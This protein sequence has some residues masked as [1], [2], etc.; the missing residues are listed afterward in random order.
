MAAS[1]S[2]IP[3]FPRSHYRI[4]LPWDQ[5]ERQLS[6]YTE[7]YALDLNPEFQRAHVWNDAQRTAYMEFKLMGGP[8]S[9][10]IFFNAPGWNKRSRT[11]M[12]LVDG[13]QR[14]ETVRMFLRGEVSIFN[15]LVYGDF[16][17][18][19]NSLDHFFFFNVADLTDK[20]DVYRWYL[21]M[22]AGGTA[23]TS[24]ELAKV[25]ALL[26]MEKGSN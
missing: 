13:K 10:E 18:R 1:F 2:L 17:D 26:D 6:Q 19:L 4:N 9:D 20:A 12:V 3:Q 7:N 15:G 8:G 16:E 5:L 11:S 24:E 25:R 14:L 21:G 23:H 22:N